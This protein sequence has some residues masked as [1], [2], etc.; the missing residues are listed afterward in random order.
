[1]VL[2]EKKHK[3]RKDY[4]CDLSGKK[5]NAGDVYVSVA[6]KVEGV[7]FCIRACKDA[8]DFVNDMRFG[9]E[10]FVDECMDRDT[11]RTLKELDREE[12]Q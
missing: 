1:M 5:I 2:S 11:Y 3:A 4:K 8:W 10:N 6:Q 7:F 12:L 9:F